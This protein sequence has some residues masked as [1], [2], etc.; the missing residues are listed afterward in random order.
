ML[1]EMEIRPSD[2]HSRDLG[3]A[4]TNRLGLKQSG[5]AVGLALNSGTPGQG[6][7]CRVIKQEEPG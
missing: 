4:M 7:F 5:A 2:L 3:I 1:I 6:G